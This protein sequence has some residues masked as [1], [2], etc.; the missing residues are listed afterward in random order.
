MNAQEIFDAVLQHARRQKVPAENA[1][2]V[3]QYR[4]PDGKRCFIGAL[5]PD[6]LYTP[7]IE[8]LEIHDVLRRFPRIRE[9]FGIDEQQ[10][11]T[12]TLLSRLQRIHDDRDPED[13]EIELKWLANDL[14]LQYQPP[15]D[16]NQIDLP[17][18][19]PAQ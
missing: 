17:L 2:R 11:T 6:E 8:G 3:C 12:L 15:G 18:E 9:F 19:E 4:A 14:S 16:V 13:W 5:I 1:D 7:K 10:M